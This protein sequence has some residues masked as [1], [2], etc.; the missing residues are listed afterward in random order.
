MRFLHS[1]YLIS[2]NPAIF[3]IASV[4]AAAVV[5][6]TRV[7]WRGRRRCFC[8]R[9]SVVVQPQ[10]LPLSSMQSL[11]HTVIALL[12]QSY[13]W[14]PL[15]SMPEEL[16]AVVAGGG[17]LPARH[18]SPGTYPSG[19]PSTAAADVDSTA[20]VSSGETFT[21]PV[22]LRITAACPFVGFRVIFCLLDNGSV[23]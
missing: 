10:S 17:T 12:S 4:G 19:I 23:L 22:F 5:S 18:S 13:R 9:C 20:V 21:V 8:R 16:A 11:S 2:G 3:P 6:L 1:L 14:T 15:S 7:L